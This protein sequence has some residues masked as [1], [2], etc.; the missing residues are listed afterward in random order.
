MKPTLFLVVPAYNEV[1]NVGR[2]VDNL[3]AGGTEMCDLAGCGALHVVLVDDGSADGTADAARS[4]APP[5]TLTVLRHEVN[6]GPGA[7]FATAFAFLQTRL[8]PD[9]RVFT[10]EGDNTSRL[11]TARRMLVRLR[12]GYDAVLASPYAYGGGFHQTSWFRLFLS[13]GAN[14][15]LKGGLGIRG[16]HT[17]SSFFR[18]YTGELL[19]RLGTVY[20][21]GIVERKGFECMAELL[22]KMIALGARLSEVEML[23]DSSLRL[24]KSKMKIV[25]TVRGYLALLYLRHR[26]AGRVHPTANA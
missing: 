5:D 13:H 18:L 11:D 9:D 6:R 16:I 12:E 23:L 15:L 24:G 7:A 20:G 2:L 22:M 17:M 3:T 14:G 19:L 8:R 21:P 25:R 4:Y 26:W 10:L 1:A